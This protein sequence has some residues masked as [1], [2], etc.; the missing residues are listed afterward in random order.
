MHTFK[1]MSLVIALAGC[2]CTMA[3]AR[4]PETFSDIYENIESNC[5]NDAYNT[6]DI[7]TDAAEIE[8]STAIQADKRQNLFG[9]VIKY[10]EKQDGADK[11]TSQLATLG[12]IE[13]ESATDDNKDSRTAM[14]CL[15]YYRCLSERLPNGAKSVKVTISWVNTGDSSK[16]KCIFIDPEESSRKPNLPPKG[17]AR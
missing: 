12:N 14:K 6:E 17:S 1:Q 15:A 16:S 11:E 2:I 5:L 8:A 10:C 4:P 9:K 3:Q 7:Q 13:C